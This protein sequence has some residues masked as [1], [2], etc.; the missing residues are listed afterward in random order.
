ME[1]FKM[2]NVKFKIAARRSSSA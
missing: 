2:K 1:Q